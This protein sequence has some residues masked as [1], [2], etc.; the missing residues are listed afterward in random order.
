MHGRFG[1]ILRSIALAGLLAGFPPTHGW[2]QFLRLGPM[3]FEAE[4]QVDAIYTTNVE[5]E[6]PSETDEE[7][8]DY[9]GILSL[10]LNSNAELSRYFIVNA[11]AGLGIEKHWN[12]P[13]LDNS[14]APFSELTADAAAELGRYV[15][16][17]LA[18]YRRTAE[19]QESIY[20]PGARKKRDVRDETEW[21]AGILYDIEW[22]TLGS[23]YTFTTERHED[24][25][26]TDADQDET[27]IN[28]EI[29]YQPLDF[30]GVSFRDERDKTKLVNEE[31]TAAEWE[32]TQTISL[33][34]G[35]TI[36]EA[37]QLTYSLGLEKEDDVS[38]EEEG[39]WEWVH[40][41]ALSDQRD[42]SESIRYALG[43]NY[44]LED[45]E[46]S[47]DVALTYSGSIEQDLSLTTAHAFRFSRTP[48]QVFGTTEESD[49]TTYSYVFTK[50]DLFIYALDLSLG[51][52]YTIDKPL[53]ETSEV[54]I[55]TEK[56]TTY[57]ANLAYARD[58]TR[59]L[60][61]VVEY[62][63]SFEDSNIEDENLVEHRVTLSYIY[64]F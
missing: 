44:S 5:Q 27:T 51:A 37:P 7:R 35:L 18:G 56:T 41:F 60:E 53:S 62:D 11:Q 34:F 16:T 24:P 14:T 48:V 19:S 45:N 12:R 46:E 17:A 29:S 50:S 8:E 61:R 54:Q 58:L 13:D 59:R 42:L 25:E 23:E 15:I 1:L 43:V 52:S 10:R 3:E 63:F 30:F 4:T 20:I 33:D 39:A 6:R 49:Q 28:S 38:N 9:Y 22:L 32:V 55:E 21:G 31:T 47:D 36:I 40:N 64:Y 26:F 57:T 2:T